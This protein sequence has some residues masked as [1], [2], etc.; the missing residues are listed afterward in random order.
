MRKRY[1]DGQL[2][3]GLTLSRIQS[4][5]EFEKFAFYATYKKSDIDKYMGLFGK[6]LI[7]RTKDATENLDQKAVDGNDGAK[8]YQLKLKTVNKL[9]IPSDDNAS[10][11]TAKL[12]KE[13][14][15][16]SNLI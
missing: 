4:S 2:K 14:D 12:L 13:P 9:R 5:K 8:I 7:N 15:F 3:K 1:V 10:D 16:R 11:I 6:N